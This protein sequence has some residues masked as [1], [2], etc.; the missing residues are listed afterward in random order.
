MVWRTGELATDGVELM[1]ETGNSSGML[2]EIDAAIANGSAVSAI[3]GGGVDVSP[4]TVSVEFEVTRDHPLVSITTMVAP[5]PDWFLG[6]RDLALFDG[7][8]FVESVTV[9]ALVYDSGTDSGRLF[10]SGDSDTQPPEPIA[11]LTTDPSESD[12]Q[13]GLPSMGEFIFEKLP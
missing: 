5:S 10:T 4:G 2:A 9:D 12:I 13:N 3:D 11:R 7:S 1:A 6:V 8:E